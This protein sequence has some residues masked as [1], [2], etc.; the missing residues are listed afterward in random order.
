MTK[1]ILLTASIIILIFFVSGLLAPMIINWM[2]SVGEKSNFVL[3]DKYNPGELL[4]YYGTFLSFLGTG[5]LGVIVLLKDYR[6]EE[7]RQDERLV[8][9]INEDLSEMRRDMQRNRGRM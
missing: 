1:R 9:R 2:F 7:N 8:D 6:M 5:F 3:S 4:E